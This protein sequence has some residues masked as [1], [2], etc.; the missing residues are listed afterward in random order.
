MFEG[1]GTAEMVSAV[2]ILHIK[3]YSCIEPTRT[4]HSLN[5]IH[6]EF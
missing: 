4:F 2:Q 3:S 5:G 6:A 1:E